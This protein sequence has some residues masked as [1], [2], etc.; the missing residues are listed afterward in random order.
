[1]APIATAILFHFVKHHTFTSHRTYGVTKDFVLGSSVYRVFL[2][3]S[4]WLLHVVY[5]QTVLSAPSFNH[6]NTLPTYT[7]ICLI[8]FYIHASHQINIA[9][10]VNYI[11]VPTNTLIEYVMHSYIAS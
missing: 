8:Y 3:Q 1:M 2:F 7:A 9:I 11:S 5:T 4:V 10:I 6:V